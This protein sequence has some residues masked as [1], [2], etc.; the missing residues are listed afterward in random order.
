LLQQLSDKDRNVRENTAT[1]LAYF[2]NIPDDVIDTLLEIWAEEE[3]EIE[4]LLQQLSDKDRNVRENTAT[5]LA[6]FNNIPDD[7]IDT[8]L[9]IWAEEEDEVVCWQIAKVL[10]NL[11]DKLLII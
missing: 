11:E 5:R 3:D 8:L 1:R 2:N 7:V 6:Y 4:E 10:G 9:E